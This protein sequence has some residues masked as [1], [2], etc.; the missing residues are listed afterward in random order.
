MD[1]I[2]KS[3]AVLVAFN[4]IRLN[5]IKRSIGLDKLRGY[6]FVQLLVNIIN[7]WSTNSVPTYTPPRNPCCDQIEQNKQEACRS[8]KCEAIKIL[9]QRLELRLS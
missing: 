1:E 7:V 2:Y 3:P 6:R 9:L 8:V 4:K 5:A